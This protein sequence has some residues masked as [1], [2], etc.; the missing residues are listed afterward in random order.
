MVRLVNYLTVATDN[1]FNT[2]R[3]SASNSAKLYEMALSNHEYLAQVEWQFVSQLNT[4]HVWDSIILLALLRDKHTNNSRL[5]VPH[6]GK[7]KDRFTLA[8]EER[9]KR[10]I[11]EGQPDAVRHACDKCL[12]IYVDGE[13]VVRVSRHCQTKQFLINLHI[14]KEIARSLSAMDSVWVVPVV[15]SF[16]ARN[17]YKT[18]GIGSARCISM[19]TIFA[20][21]L[22]ATTPHQTVQKLAQTKNTRH[23]RRKT[24]SAEQP[25]SRSRNVYVRHNSPIQRSQFQSPPMNPYLHMRQSPSGLT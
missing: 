5:E 24:R 12:R 4:D 11:H 20:P 18:T 13:G 9:N 22:D 23:W 21:L 2:R 15:G 3:V 6:E 17:H 14:L 19:T 16:A 10:I 1:G 25:L 8:M 7:Q